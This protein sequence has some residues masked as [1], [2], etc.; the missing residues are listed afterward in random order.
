M[1]LFIRSKLHNLQILVIADIIKEAGVLFGEDQQ[2]LLGLWWLNSAYW[3]KYTNS[4][5]RSA[6]PVEPEAIYNK[7]LIGALNRPL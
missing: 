2:S 1:L 4:A 7:K 6:K 5:A 3:T